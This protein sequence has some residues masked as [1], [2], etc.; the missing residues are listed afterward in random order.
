MGKNR[1]EVE[2]HPEETSRENRKK[3]SLASKAKLQNKLK[4]NSLKDFQR[5]AQ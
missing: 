2:G 1:E 4:G 3:P 5:N